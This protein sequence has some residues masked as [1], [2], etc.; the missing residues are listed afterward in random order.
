MR[1]NLPPVLSAASV[2][3]VMLV[4]QVP[5]K[6]ELADRRPFTDRAGKTLFRWLERA[7]VD[8]ATARTNIYIAAMAGRRDRRMA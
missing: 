5:G 4:G 3:R 6:S 2:P 8:E 7:G 1:R